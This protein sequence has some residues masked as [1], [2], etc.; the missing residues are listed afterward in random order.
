MKNFPRIDSGN[1]EIPEEW[2]R[3]AYDLLLVEGPRKLRRRFAIKYAE[4][5]TDYIKAN[6]E[7]KRHSELRDCL[8][9]DVTNFVMRYQN[10]SFDDK[11]DMIEELSR[12]LFIW[13][14]FGFERVDNIHYLI[15]NVILTRKEKG[16]VSIIGVR[17]F[18]DWGSDFNEGLIQDLL[19]AIDRRRDVS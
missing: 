8:F 19:D 5:F 16:L 18:K 9:V 10:A 1:I 3:F 7:F 17:D 12:Y 6:R 15:L 4:A 11:E 2:R 14:D 13:F